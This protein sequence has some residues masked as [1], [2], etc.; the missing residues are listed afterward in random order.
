MT[1]LIFLCC[2]AVSAIATTKSVSAEP[3]RK[4][5]L[6]PNIIMILA[7]DMAWYDTPVRMD[8]SLENSA[9]EIMRSLRD[10]V[11][12]DHAYVWNLQKL[13]N[14]GMLFR[15]AYSGA[16][17]CT[18]TR[19]CLQ[20]GMTTA[21]HRLSVELG[22]KGIGEFNLKPELRKFPMIPSGVRKP[23]PNNM[24]TIPEALAPFGYQC[25]HYGK[26]HLEP[27]PAAEGYVDSDGDTDNNQGKTYDPKDQTIPAD[28]DNAKRIQEITDKTIAFMTKQ[29]EAGKPFYV[30]LS[31]YAAHAPWECKRSSRAL[32]QNHPDVVA[33]NQG[34]TDP[35]KLK[36][37][38][39][40][41]VFFGMIYE[42][43][44]SVGRL[45]DAIE[46]RALSE[47]TYVIFKS[48]NGYRRFDTRN[49]VQPFYGAKWFL[50]Q[51]GIRVP[52]IVKGP[53]VPAGEV[54]TANVVTYDL[55][56]T[57][58][59]WAGGDPSRMT[60]IDGM[61][62]KNLLKGETPSEALLS[63]SIYFHYP[64]YRSAMPMSVIVK[65]NHKLAYCWDATL[66]SDIEV[67][68]PKLLFDL[69]RDP[70]EFNN[71]TA[72]DPELADQLWHDLDQYLSSIEARRPRDNSEA[73]L[74]DRGQEFE[75]DG[76]AERRDTFAP[77][78]SVRKTLPELNDKPRR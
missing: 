43:D 38:N 37:K 4:S 67:S 55:L 73:Y 76:S 31:H 75:A 22:G 3:I 21:R 8:E 29:H 62:L 60:K 72:T 77:F 57:F 14:Q 49:F 26:W 25:A 74:S 33:Y 78:E 18:P 40:P 7:D 32:F 11:D 66:R 63:R 24:V 6:P 36:R 12:P 71:L 1:R 69:D 61:S 30:Q 9:Q 2:V 5:D 64:H 34:E 13:A 23:F 70:G 65:G 59:D 16:P 54:C 44:R 58:Y 50:W 56:P 17:Q 19:A 35:G 53:G 39:D 27:D 68:D 15:N 42:L 41:A 51:A 52:M 46:Q 48:D 45:L 20:T 10:P 47:N 28:L